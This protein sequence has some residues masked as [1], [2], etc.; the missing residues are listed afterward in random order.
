M[1]KIVPII[2][3]ATGIC[4]LSGCTANISANPYLLSKNLSNL[5]SSI[6]SEE[7]ID[8]SSESIESSTY[9]NYMCD[10]YGY[11]RPYL[12]NKSNMRT[13][14]YDSNMFDLESLFSIAD[15]VYT[16]NQRYETIKSELEKSIETTQ[17]LLKKI[18]NNE[19][20]IS[21]ENKQ[22]IKQY[23]SD[24]RKSTY[25]LNRTNRMVNENINDINMLK[26]DIVNNSRLL[27]EKYI[28]LLNCLDER[29]TNVENALSSLTMINGLITNENNTYDQLE[30]NQD[31]TT[32]TD[33]NELSTK[34]K[35]KLSDS[36][37]EFFSKNSVLNKNENTK[38]QTKN[39]NLSNINNSN[40]LT[41]NDKTNLKT[42]NHVQNN[43]STTT[44]TINEI[45][46]AT[47]NNNVIKS[48]IENTKDE[49]N[50]PDNAIYAENEKNNIDSYKTDNIT[51]VD[52]YGPDISNIDSY[53]MRP[54]YNT[55]D[56]LPGAPYGGAMGGYG[57]GGVG[58]S[59]LINNPNS[60]MPG[61]TTQNKINLKNEINNKNNDSQNNDTN[62]APTQQ[63]QTFN[64][65]TETGTAT[66]NVKK[67]LKNIDT[68]NEQT[69]TKTN[70]DS[71]KKIKNENITDTAQRVEKANTE[72]VNAEKVNTEKDNTQNKTDVNLP[73]TV[74]TP[75][76][77]INLK[78]L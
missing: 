29:I 4:A 48:N 21:N 3:L 16:T 42:N 15:D 40:T 8:Y 66:E 62:T 2:V 52:T 35:T 28:E 50:V 43:S 46:N 70:I 5:Q 30:Q 71:M 17:E 27:N 9:N 10:E 34:Q 19:V 25:S 74:L 51:N 63:N 41:N 54:G 44:N 32:L 60:N 39:N 47:Q 67:S 20:L 26:E 11:C 76:P 57:M 49:N 37:K 7:L 53:W 72:R 38:T 12:R 18:I 65:N 78:T 58:N 77:K 33:E 6:L 23:S 73:N 1:K 59:N 69:I 56:F 45:N 14:S 61:M 55:N 64:N 13:Q 68:Y 24:I 75:S 31:T 36:L 22:S